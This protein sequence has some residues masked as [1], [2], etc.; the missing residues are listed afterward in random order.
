MVFLHKSQCALPVV[1]E[2]GAIV[3][4]VGT[5]V[6][7]SVVTVSHVAVNV[8][9]NGSTVHFS[10][11]TKAH[12]AVNV[13]QNVGTIHFSFATVNGRSYTSARHLHNT[14]CQN[15]SHVS[16]LHL[17]KEVILASGNFLTLPLARPTGG[18]QERLAQ[19]REGGRLKVALNT[20]C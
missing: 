12:V 19:P 5:N 4:Q 10:F 2:V 8:C 18:P 16:T 14:C 1:S 13:R 6:S 15:Y 7:Q 3:S 9:Q 20:F 11:A 17:G